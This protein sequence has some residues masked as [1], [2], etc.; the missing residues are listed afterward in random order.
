[1]NL[2]GISK[3]KADALRATLRIAL[4]ALTLVAI[5]VQ[6]AFSIRERGASVLN[7]LS[8]FTIESNVFAAVVFL[9]GGLALLRIGTCSERMATWRGAATVYMATTGVVYSA[10]L[11]GNE[12]GADSTIQ[13]VNLTLHYIMPCAVVLDWLAAP[14]NPHGSYPHV[15]ARWLAFPLAYFLY[16]ILRGA[17][18][19]WYPYP[20]LNPAAG[21][22]YGGV[23]LTALA[24]TMFV[25]ALAMAVAWYAK[26]RPY[27]P[28]T[29]PM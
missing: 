29:P 22:G 26:R 10:L 11:R 4:A 5:V 3:P 13:W 27:V 16:S 17:F 28:E 21:A 1:M 18:T 9:I 12:A 2:A 14:A 8:F 24:I 25:A 19:G 6:I 23:A 20:F 7:L 15:L